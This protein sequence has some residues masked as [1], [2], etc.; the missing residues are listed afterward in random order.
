MVDTAGSPL[1]IAERREE[2]YEERYAAEWEQQFGKSTARQALEKEIRRWC[3]AVFEDVSPSFFGPVGRVNEPCMARLQHDKQKICWFTHPRGWTAAQKGVLQH[4]LGHDPDK[5]GTHTFR[6]TETWL[7]FHL[8]FGP[9]P[10]LKRFGGAALAM[11]TALLGSYGS[12]KTITLCA[13]RDPANQAGYVLKTSAFE[14][15][16]LKELICLRQL[17][18][19]LHTPREQGISLGEL[20]EGR[21]EGSLRK[22]KHIY[23]HQNLQ[24]LVAGYNLSTI[25]GV[26]NVLAL[27]SEAL[28]SL[29]DHGAP[30][31]SL[32]EQAE[33]LAAQI[34]ASQIHPTLKTALETLLTKVNDR[35]PLQPSRM[36]GD[37]R[38]ANLLAIPDE[39]DF[40]A[41]DFSY[42]LGIIDWELSQ[43]N[44]LG[45]LDLAQLAL[46]K[47][48]LNRTNLDEMFEGDQLGRLGKALE[49][50]E[51]PGSDCS[52]AEIVALHLA[53][54]A[55]DRAWG[56]GGTNRGEG[57]AKALDFPWPLN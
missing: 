57:Y 38:P 1:P 39:H 51:L 34:Q 7:N 27:A 6:E 20:N 43:P 32:A 45:I 22:L 52:I 54:Y 48:N 31:T 9:A 50:S 19:G 23:R 25:P 2:R 41:R 26:A 47:V 21:H 10:R 11:G 28:R 46:D 12:S 29:V 33:Q 55:F 37:L 4:A 15:G 44:R 36:H 30:P 3:E 35:T 8:C 13:P 56:F 17:P 16:L 5:L 42:E 14:D 53:T 40:A 49:R 18:A 24:T